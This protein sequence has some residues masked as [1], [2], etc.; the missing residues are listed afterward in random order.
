MHLEREL[1]DAI[2]WTPKTS[3]EPS[4]PSES[5]MLDSYIGTEN[6]STFRLVNLFEEDDEF[7]S[8]DYGLR[9]L[10]EEDP[11]C[12]ETSTIGTSS[13]STFSFDNDQNDDSLCLFVCLF[14]CCLSVVWVIAIFVSM[15]VNFFWL[16]PELSEI[17][18][19]QKSH[20]LRM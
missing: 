11:D 20:L 10:F 17:K 16:F 8:E 12:I 13:K 19:P 14:V 1:I 9:S 3:D 4:V 18:F 15:I 2:N 7:D 6:D 5:K